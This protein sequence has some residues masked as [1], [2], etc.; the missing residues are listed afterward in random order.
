MTVKKI[1]D[2]IAARRAGLAKLEEVIAFLREKGFVE[3]KARSGNIITLQKRKGKGL[4][5]VDVPRKR[6]LNR[7]E[8]GYILRLAGIM[9]HKKTHITS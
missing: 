4:L 5:T 1:E 6:F 3:V 7:E 9:L 2:M 8:V